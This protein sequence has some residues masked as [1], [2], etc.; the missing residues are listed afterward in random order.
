V[1]SQDFSALIESGTA[2]QRLF[3]AVEQADVP[4]W[5]DFYVRVFVNLVDAGPQT[6]T[7]DPHFA[8]SFAFFGNPAAQH[9]ASHAAGE[10]EHPR[11]LVDL[12]H[13]LRALQSKGALD[14]A[15]PLTVQLVPTQ[16][17]EQT[18]LEGVPLVLSGIDII[19]SPV[20]VSPAEGKQ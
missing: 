7:D 12:T 13:T 11:F 14:A 20:I 2:P 1:R 19:A 10:A 3:L 9:P 17:G 5:Q 6:S 15:A 18:K 4:K 8:G 16:I